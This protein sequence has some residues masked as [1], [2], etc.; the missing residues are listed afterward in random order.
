MLTNV[1]YFKL[2]N[3]VREFDRISMGVAFSSLSTGGCGLNKGNDD[4]QKV[5]SATAKGNDDP[6]KVESAT[7]PQKCSLCIAADEKR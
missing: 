2:Q 6:H 4:P 5:E 3:I 7:A 1:L